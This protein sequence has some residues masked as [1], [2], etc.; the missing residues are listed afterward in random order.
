VAGEG[1]TILTHEVNRP[2]FSRVLATPAT[3]SP[4]HLT[5]SGKKGVV[6]GVR[7]RHV[8]SDGTREV[9]I[10]HIAGNAHHDGLLMVYLPKERLLIQADAFTPAPANAPPPTPPHPFSV[11]LADNITRLNLD[12][13]QLLPLHGRIVP[14]AE[15]HRA[16]GR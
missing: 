1:I 11:N 9:E 13:A 12:V 15:L 2:F 16:V 7:D 3:V 10:H 5:R 6:D 8:L 4:D 14:V